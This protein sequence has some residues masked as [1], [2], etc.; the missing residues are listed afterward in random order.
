MEASEL[1]IPCMDAALQYGASDLHFVA[2]KAPCLTLDG[3]MLPIDS[4]PPLSEEATKAVLDCVVTD[5]EAQALLKKQG[6]V[7]FRYRYQKRSFRVNAA[8]ELKGYAI[9]L[10]IIPEKV[11][12]PEQIG[13][14]DTIMNLIRR[15]QGLFLV[16]GVTG[17]GKSTTLAAILQH[18][19]NTE[20]RKI[21]T[22]EQ[23]IEYVLAHGTSVVTQFDVPT[24]VTSF[25]DALRSGLRQAPNIILVGELRDAETMETALH[26][27]ETGHRVFA[28]VHSKSAF[29]TPDRIIEG[30][31]ADLQNQTRV[32]LASCLLGV[33][34]QVLV[35]KTGGSGRV[36][37]YEFMLNNPAISN[38]IRTGKREQMK[39]YLQTGKTDGMR[40]L[41][42]HLAEL[43]V[44]GAVDEASALEKA[45]D[46]D[47][48]EKRISDLRKAE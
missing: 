27:A 4:L 38:L 42:D 47:T 24:H 5:S 19:A 40:L 20:L 17:S 33:M 39:S 36:L 44:S 25:A 6:Y 13:L 45:R 37:A 29:E 48:L 10:R 9:T 15:P 12:T 43:V 22:V 11:L 23:P 8:A 21:L 18:L 30:M 28:T 35:R 2:G 31:P 46:L 1:L 32:S 34:T 7:D 14:N 41:E 26:A 16:T 3:D